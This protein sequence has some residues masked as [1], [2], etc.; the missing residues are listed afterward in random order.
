M[1]A[2]GKPAPDVY[3]KAAELLG[4]SPAACAGI[5]DSP[6]GLRAVRSAG[7]LS[8]MVP[9]RIPYSAE[10]APNVDL[11]LDSLAMLEQAIL[12]KE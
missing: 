3:L 5:E 8:I 12:D 10:I 11:C 1:V 7:M 4:V 2:H 9:D 6:G